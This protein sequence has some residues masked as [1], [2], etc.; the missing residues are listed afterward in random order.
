MGMLGTGCVYSNEGNY[1]LHDCYTEAQ[2]RQNTVSVLYYQ[3]R[4]QHRELDLLEV[5]VVNYNHA[6][7][8]LTMLDTL[9]TLAIPKCHSNSRQCDI[10]GNTETE[11]NGLP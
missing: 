3:I 4:T 2:C 9:S 6:F 10:F 7:I 8:L 5:S 1:M 11:R